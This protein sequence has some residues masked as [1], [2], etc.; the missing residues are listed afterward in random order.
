MTAALGRHAAHSDSGRRRRG[1]E[2]AFVA[3]PPLFAVCDGMGGA[4]AGELASRLAASALEEA[5]HESGP[6]LDLVAAILEGNRRIHQR[7][8]ADP[9]AAGMGTTVT[10]MLV[11]DGGTVTVGHVGDSRAYRLRGDALEQLTPDHSLV[12][13]L[14]RTG[15]ISPEEAEG[16][17]QRA[18]ITR[19]LG[20]DTNVEVDVFHLA[21]EPGDLYLLCSDGL[22][23]MI[24]DAEVRTI[25]TR[26]RAD[27]PR[28]TR[29]LVAAAN[30][31][32]GEDNIT[33]VCFE[34]VDAPAP[35]GGEPAPGAGS[36]G[37]QTAVIPI[38]DEDTFDGLDIT[39]EQTM[40]LPAPETATGWA[41]G[42]DAAEPDAFT[43][44]AAPPPGAETPTPT[45][46]EVTRRSHHRRRKLPYVI[47]LL[48]LL[49]AT[50]AAG[51]VLVSRAHFVGA[52][53]RGRLV[54]Y[55]GVPWDITSHVR[56]YRAVYVSPVLAFQ[57]SQQERIR[58]FDHALRSKRL[59]IAEIA[60]FEHELLR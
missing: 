2:D 23:G 1:N 31:A 59:A 47:A 30:A 8:L 56:L 48:A 15:Q 12:A 33:C 32:G 20:T 57:L 46:P 37:E 18:V 4:L 60:V 17:P 14:V 52:D 7:S 34:L 10:A 11:G 49:A 24:G 44:P 41:E 39:A 21:G 51:V 27:L 6:G 13:E 9:A 26:E 42:T 50:A 36:P 3:V 29:E 25:L 19:A 43:A 22:T 55:Q 38:A 53:S 35:A 58:L 16:H 54:V 5:V 28:A 40:V 45:T